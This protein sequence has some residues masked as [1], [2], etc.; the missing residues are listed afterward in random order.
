[1]AEVSGCSKRKDRGSNNSECRICSP[2]GKKIC[3]QDLEE[4]ELN[5]GSD[6]ILGAVETNCT[7]T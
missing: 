4:S 5:S 3:G 2:E 6:A 7:T 1:M